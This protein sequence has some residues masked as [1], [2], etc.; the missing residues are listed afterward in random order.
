MQVSVYDLIVGDVV[1]LG[2]GDEVSPS[3]S[4]VTLSQF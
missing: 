1:E 3:A 2:T 4:V